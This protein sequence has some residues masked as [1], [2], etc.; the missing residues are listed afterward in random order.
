MKAV[1][2]QKKKQP[3]PP[4]RL[5]LASKELLASSIKLRHTVYQLCYDSHHT[6]SYIEELKNLKYARTKGGYDVIE[7]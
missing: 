7:F 1:A 5:L 3:Q 2:S 4:L 6:V